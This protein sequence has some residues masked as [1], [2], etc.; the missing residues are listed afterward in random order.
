[1][2]KIYISYKRLCLLLAL[3]LTLLLAACTVAPIA[4]TSAT[5]ATEEPAAEES[6]DMDSD[7]SSDTS[8]ET[9]AET[10]TDD[11]ASAETECEEGYRLF[12]HER[13]ATDPVCIPIA[14]ERVL[15]LDMAS[16]EMLLILEQTPVGT[17]QW[18][19]N[20]LP[21]ILPQYADVLETLPGFGYPADLEA[22]AA[23]Q[24]DLILAPA[25]TI[26][27]ELAAEIAPVVVP[28]GGV[29]TD[30]KAGM[31]FWSEVFNQ[32]E[33]YAQ[34]EENYDQRVAELQEALG[35]PEEL[36]V[37]TISASSYGISLWLPDTAPGRILSD[38]GLSRPEAQ[39]LVGEAAEER[40]GAMQYVEVSLERL[41][42]VDGDAIFYFTYA[43]TDPDTA[44]GEVAAIEAIN[45][46]PLWQ[47]LEAVQA[48]SAFFVGGHWWRSQTYLL[49][50]LV[51][52]DLFT[53]LTDTTATT[54]AMGE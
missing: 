25:D 53:H 10:G 54:P 28:D 19:L 1:M 18:I 7:T 44:A 3:L 36:E 35:A 20:E 26:D 43:S 32:Q 48:D 41:D 24:P 37:S 22:V 30:W 11:A 13:L 39:S 12:D 6:S 21:V 31:H 45:E 23:Q 27:V 52:D 5:D 46:R 33:L 16:L 4:E 38:V 34:M 17:A 15:T 14:P 50:N 51:I 9:A 2:T 8:T 49:A 47:A 40:Y 29:Y 42:L